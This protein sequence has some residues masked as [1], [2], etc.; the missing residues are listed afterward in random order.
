ML[1]PI[2]LIR[3]AQAHLTDTPPSAQAG[4]RHCRSWAAKLL[5]AAPPPEDLL[6]PVLSPQRALG[7]VCREQ[8]GNFEFRSVGPAICPESS[9]KI[10]QAR[11]VGHRRPSHLFPAPAMPAQSCY[12]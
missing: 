10:P 2:Q 5:V 11:P 1:R 6:N 4:R 7:E 8:P 12:A 3:L 9:P